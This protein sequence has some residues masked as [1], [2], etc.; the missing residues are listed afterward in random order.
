MTRHKHDGLW[1]VSTEK[2]VSALTGPPEPGAAHD[3]LQVLAPPGIVKR[4]TLLLAASQAFVGVGNQ[5]VPTL[6]AIIVARLLGSAHL[7]GMATSSLGVSRF[8]VS[9]PIGRVADVY[10]RRIAVVLGLLFGLAGALG[11]G[12]SVISGSFVLFLASILV[13][14]AGVSAGYQLRVA[15]ADMY[16]P[17]RRA[18]GLGFVLTGSLVGAFGGPILITAAE[19]WSGPLGLDSPGPE[20]WRGLALAW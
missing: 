11:P 6:G 10:G 20:W 16:P 19:T 4:N 15:A 2:L 5:M 9:Y 14:G 3:A 18:E 17:R 8:L 13:F 12:L 1:P 7:A